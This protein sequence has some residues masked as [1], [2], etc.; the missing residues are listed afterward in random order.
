[1]F[2]AQKIVQHNFVL[3]QVN[4]VLG[5]SCPHCL[6]SLETSKV[7]IHQSAYHGELITNYTTKHVISVPAVILHLDSASKHVEEEGERQ[8]WGT[9]LFERQYLA[10]NIK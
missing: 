9:S 5:S 10:N 3:F 4:T 1:M 2:F 6:Q 7:L 8:I